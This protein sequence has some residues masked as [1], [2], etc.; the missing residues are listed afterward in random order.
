M[1]VKDLK[2][3]WH[4]WNLSSN[5]NNSKSARPRSSGHLRARELLK[6]IYP[7]DQVLE[8][9]PLPGTLLFCD[10]FLPLR[11]L[12][13]EVHGKQH[14]E[15]VAY[16]HGSAEGFVAS[17]KRDSEKTEWASINNLK[18]V[19]LPDT[20]GNNEWRRRIESAFKTG[21]SPPEV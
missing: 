11:R 9:L 14:F 5:V 20:E 13:I 4:N 7:L 21:G 10:F 16:F 8:E 3:K 19:I 15:F 17:K 12:M 6:E 2:G 18:Q 1:K